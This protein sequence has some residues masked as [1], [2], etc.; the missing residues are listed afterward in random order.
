MT[1]IGITVVWLACSLGISLAQI[2]P[3]PQ[4]P[5]NPAKPL[6]IRVSAGVMQGLVEQRVLPQYPDQALLK[7]IQGD[8][9]FKILVDATG[10]VILSVPVEGDPLLVA[11]GVDAVRGYRFRPYLLNGVPVANVES[12]LGFHFSVQRSGGGANGRVECMPS[13]P[14]RPEFRTGV[15]T[16]QGVLVLWPHEVSRVEPQLPPGLSGKTG[17][18]YLVITIGVDGKVQDVKVV[19]GDE[20]FLG[21][22]VAAAKQTVYEPQLVGGKPSVATTEASYHFGPRQ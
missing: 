22:V 18:V 20:A 4:P 21:P 19:G 8:V 14:D 6:K 11:A 5:A 2:D 10:K 15:V 9:I 13:V 17:S 16:D 7:G 1:R 12:Q 3:A